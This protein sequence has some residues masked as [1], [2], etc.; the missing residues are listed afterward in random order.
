[1]RVVR[2]LVVVSAV[3][4]S[5][6]STM[7]LAGAQAP[8]AK[9]TTAKPTVAKPA[10]TTASA[11]NTEEG[12]PV[13]LSPLSTTSPS[14]AGLELKAI[15]Q[16]DTK[17]RESQRGAQPQRL[18]GRIQPSMLRSV[19]P[20]TQQKTLEHFQSVEEQ[21]DKL[22]Q[23][24]MNE[25]E[26][27]NVQIYRYQIETQI[28]SQKFKEWEKPVNSLESFW[29]GVQG[30]G[31]RGF[32][33]EQDY[34]NYL[35][36]LTDI[37]R[38][39]DENIANMRAGVARGFTPPKITLTGRDQTI[40]PIANAK[41]ADM[42]PFWKPFT[43]MP[44][45]I[46]TAEQARLRA[47]AKRVI[48]TQVIPAYK[49]LLA[50]WNDEYYPHTQNSIA[51]EALPDGKAYYKAQIKRYTT[52]DMTPEEIHAFG[53]AEVAKI[54][55][56]M[57]DTMAEAKFEGD[58]P[59]FLKFLRTDPQFYPK[60]EDELLGKVSYMMKEFDDKADRYFGYL[61][62]G[63]F[64][65]HPVP[66]EVA[67]Y[68]PAG[69]GGPGG[70]SINL[71]DLPSRPLFGMPALTLHE[72]APGH[73]W[74]GL[75]AREHMDPDGFRGGGSAFGEG[76]ALYCERLGT[77]MDM[78][79]TPYEKFGMLSFQSWRASRLVV[80]TG[81]HAMG[82]TREQAQQYLRDNTV[83]SEHDIEEEIDR[84]I[85]WPGQA[86]SYYLGMTEIMKERKHAQEVLGPKFNLR[87]FHDAI[88]ATGGVPL[89]V[90]DEYLEVW[91]KG[92][93]VGPYP[94]MEK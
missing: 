7:G 77:E 30:T 15:H 26:R 52:L 84:Y 67:P 56:E 41:S 81:M 47:E 51:A 32:R 90:L 59:A 45:T 1:M 58:F 36:W 25:S 17:W 63:R 9:P 6:L 16:A 12:N 54:H 31:Q 55:Q 85:S 11:T 75:I 83:L 21:V 87:A 5:M 49:P 74:A 79:H 76:W 34:L 8:A 65:I 86:L 29:S 53:Q 28:A 91:I 42:T 20:A 60:T 89:P 46:N 18:I 94:E 39:Y 44:S 27:M 38:F 92:G 88:L 3:A 64:G 66:A 73:S 22:D 19:D 24:A 14:K 57:L 69:F 62:R 23:A 50:F 48:E 35:T 68:Q 78:Y 71:Y 80:D 10:A 61:P 82:W 33:T 2:A 72:A 37:P 70:F 43:K 93:G 4:V 13:A 40:A